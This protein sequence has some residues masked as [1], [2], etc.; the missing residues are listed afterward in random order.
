MPQINERLPKTSVFISM[1]YFLLKNTKVC[2][3]IL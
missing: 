2:A 1:N 3:W